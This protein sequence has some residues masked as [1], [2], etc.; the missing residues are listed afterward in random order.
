MESNYICF[1]T[2]RSL[3]EE[4]CAS[5]KLMTIFKEIICSHK[6]P[7]GGTDFYEYEHN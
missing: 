2:G 6:K 1:L 3:K 5:T 4:S 7:P